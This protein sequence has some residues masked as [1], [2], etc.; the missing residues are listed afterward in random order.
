MFWLLRNWTLTSDV[1]SN[2]EEQ[3]FDCCAKLMNSRDRMV[4]ILATTD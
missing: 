4:W 2:R 1:T 3:L